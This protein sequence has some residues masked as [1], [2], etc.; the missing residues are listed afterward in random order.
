[1]ANDF[2]IA[3]ASVM[4]GFHPR[5]KVNMQ[6]HWR[7]LPRQ[8]TRIWPSMKLRRHR[9]TCPVLNSTHRQLKKSYTWLAGSERLLSYI[10]WHAHLNIEIIR[11]EVM[12][13]YL[14]VS[15]TDKIDETLYLSLR[16]QP[17]QLLLAL[18]QSADYF[19][20]GSGVRC[21]GGMRS[22]SR[23]RLLWCMSW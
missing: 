8:M 16:P 11:F 15:V 18:F 19:A 21:W 20:R 1:M 13:V 17:N 5:V 4:H 7:A 9:C 2:K 23:N 14:I 12:S 10:L 6:L 3:L 22:R